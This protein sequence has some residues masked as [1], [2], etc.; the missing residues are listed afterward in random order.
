MADEIVI[1]ITVS[2][3][4]EGEMI[5]RRLLE[6]RLIACANIVPGIVSLFRWKGEICREDELLVIAKSRKDLFN[7]IVDK[8]R[9]LH[10]YTVPEIIALPVV[11]GFDDYLKWLRETTERTDP[12]N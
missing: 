10:S 4:E 2:S 7:D 1:Y 5:S 12:G 9:G 8:V 6:E 3:S 11:N